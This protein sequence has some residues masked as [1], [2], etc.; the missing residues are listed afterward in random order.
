MTTTSSTSAKLVAL[1]LLVKNLTW[2][3]ADLLASDSL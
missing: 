3:P 2:S 1:A